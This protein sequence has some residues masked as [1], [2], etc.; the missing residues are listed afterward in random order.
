MKL[1]N[2]PTWPDLI[3]FEKLSFKGA[4]QFSV[5]IVLT[6]YSFNWE[7]LRD[8]LCRR[9]KEPFRPAFLGPD[10]SNSVLPY[11]GSSKE[12]MLVA[13]NY[14]KGADKVSVIVLVKWV[15]SGCL[16][17]RKAITWVSFCQMFVYFVAQKKHCEFPGTLSAPFKSILLVAVSPSDLSWLASCYHQFAS[18]ANVYLWILAMAP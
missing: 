18:S 11:C 12:A 5:E 8:P 16:F 3:F 4:F 7:A 9:P 14:I 15:S 10:L 17:H 13:I 1:E 2:R 6:I